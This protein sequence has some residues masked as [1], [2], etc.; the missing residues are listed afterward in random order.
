M[1]ESGENYLETILLLKKKKGNVRSID[2]AREL[3]FSKPS[4]SRAVGLLK[5]DGFI[6]TDKDG[7]I[8]LTKDGLAMAERIYDRHQV[9]TEFL[10]NTA[11]VSK[12]TAEKDAC[13][14]EHIL[15]EETYQGIKKF[16]KE[17][18]YAAKETSL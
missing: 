12:E 6:E 10:M 13:K 9:L 18:F 11:M 1:Y 2:V 5:E 14:I 3:G 8:L 16:G 15:S 7:M 17:K 4:V